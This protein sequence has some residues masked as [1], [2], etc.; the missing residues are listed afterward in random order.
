M[1]KFEYFEPKGLPEVFEVLK[2]YGNQASLLA[3]GT[4]LINKMEQKKCNPKYVVN[5]KTIA[6]DS[7]KKITY[8]E[9]SGLVIGS[10]V[11]INELETSTIIGEKYSVISQAARTLGTVQ[12]RNIATLGG[13]LC[14]ASPSAD[15]IPSL[16]CLGAQVIITSMEGERSVMLEDFFL[17]NGKT[18]LGIADILKE[19]KV[20]C[21]PENTGSV[22]LKHSVR[23]TLE[24][25]IV[26][27][28]TLISI[29]PISQRCVKAR[30]ALGAVAPK[31]LRIR[32]AEEL[33][34]NEKLNMQ[35]INKASEVAQKECQ[36]IDDVRS[37]AE[38]RRHMVKVLTRLAI[39]RAS[40]LSLSK[41]NFFPEI[42]N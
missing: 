10:L 31:P 17:G 15:M 28:G 24:L 3:G 33:L 7:F 2:Q 34:E 39:A 25:A 40:N 19:I 26:S 13:N 4:D 35:L 9:S 20:P 11:T 23:K 1:N 29:D 41:N 22:Y 38:Y 30:I 12:V 6:D 37:T 8:N 18:V 16:I 27:A 14:N 32:G 36:P 21:A 5:L 42:L